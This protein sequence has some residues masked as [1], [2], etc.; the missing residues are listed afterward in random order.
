[1][2][3]LL[4]IIIL[5]LATQFAFGHS[6]RTDSNGGHYNRKTGEHHYYGGPKKYAPEKPADVTMTKDLSK[7]HSEK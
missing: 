1:M 4:T 5:G 7:T 6:G 2:K 3:I